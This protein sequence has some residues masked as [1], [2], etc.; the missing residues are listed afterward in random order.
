MLTPA[1]LSGERDRS[2]GSFEPKEQIGSSPSSFVRVF[3]TCKNRKRSKITG[4]SCENR[5]SL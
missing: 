4:N 3:K 2:I 5:M 1:D